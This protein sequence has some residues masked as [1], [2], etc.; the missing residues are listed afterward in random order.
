MATP[1][2]RVE[3]AGL[4]ALATELRSLGDEAPRA[5]LRALNRA[6]TSVTTRVVHWL[7]SATGVPIMRIRKS[8]R[9]RGATMRRPEATVGIYGGR[10]P[11]I[12][13]GHDQQRRLMPAHA[14]RARMPASGHIGIFQRAPNARP[15]RIRPGVW[16]TL[17]IREVYGPPWTEFLTDVG[18][19]DLVAWGGERLRI[20][21]EREIAAVHDRH[22]AA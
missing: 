17:P 21:L 9:S 16:H 20:E 11:L 12:L 3:P 15:R 5:L 10:A 8:I 4:N 19:A 22:A 7:N 6:R 1:L 18:L 2:V 14:F 13:F